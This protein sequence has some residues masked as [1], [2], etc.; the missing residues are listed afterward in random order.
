MFIAKPS[1]GKE[2]RKLQSNVATKA[3]FTTSIFL[4]VIEIFD[5]DNILI[6]LKFVVQP[7]KTHQI[8]NKI[9]IIWIRISSSLFFKLKLKL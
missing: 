6:T 7:P 8:R 4:S 5:N 9:V 2:N 3:S 1:K